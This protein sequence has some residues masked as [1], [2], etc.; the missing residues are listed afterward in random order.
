MFDSFIRVIYRA[1]KGQMNENI[2]QLIDARVDTIN[3]ELVNY[4]SKFVCKDVP[5]D[6]R[7]QFK[8]AYFKEKKKELLFLNQMVHM[9]EK[10][11]NAS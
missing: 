6:L 11:E 3:S 5:K 7:A 1:Y 8:C 2:Y 9:M 4:D 10:E